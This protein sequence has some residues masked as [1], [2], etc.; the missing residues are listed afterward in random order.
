M[1]DRDIGQAIASTIQQATARLPTR[2]TE[3]EPPIGVGP[4]QLPRVTIPDD[5][6]APVRE[7]VARLPEVEFERV[8][9]AIRRLPER[10]PEMIRDIE[11]IKVPSDAPIP[12]R[13]VEA[14]PI[15][16]RQRDRR[17]WFIGLGLL[18]I[19]GGI[20]LV[21][22]VA[23]MMR[24][25]RAAPAPTDPVGVRTPADMAAPLEEMVEAAR[26]REAAREPAVI[27]VQAWTGDTD[28]SEATETIEH[29]AE[30]V[31]Q[32]AEAIEERA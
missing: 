13:L 28:G 11:P 3:L 22:G 15:L 18:A 25:R 2:T 21:A 26:E 7:A 9:E 17:P 1:P 23:G 19:V 10:I 16:E 20:A 12:E 5:L 30:K 29:D 27:D 8:A 24:R 4:L 6:P 32:R 31:E 14:V